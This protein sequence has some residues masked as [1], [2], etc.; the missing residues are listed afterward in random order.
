MRVLVSIC[1]VALI[2][3]FVSCSSEAIKGGSVS[4]VTSVPSFGSLWNQ[5][6]ADCNFLSNSSVTS[7]STLG[8]LYK[9]TDFKADIAKM[10]EL[11]YGQI[12]MPVN[13]IPLKFA[14]P[15]AIYIWWDED[16][17]SKDDNE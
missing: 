7:T 6:C 12:P 9:G 13:V 8:S 11:I 15:E 14:G 2:A 5:N 10:H 3:L 1:F 4:P 16:G 17:L